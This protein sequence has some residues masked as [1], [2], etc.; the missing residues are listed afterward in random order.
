MTPTQPRGP[1]F[2]ILVVGGVGVASCCLMT[3]GVM[4]LGAFADDA[5]SSSTSG[6]EGN[7][8]LVAG[9]I[10]RGAAMTQPLSG[11]R[12]VAQYGSI[13]NNVVGRAGNFEWVQTNSS[14]S[15]Y[16]LNFDDD[17]SY[18][19]N[20]VSA[21]T[22]YGQKS[23]SHCTEKG[24]WELNGTQLVL[25]PES[26]AAEYSNSSGSQQKED[27]NLAERRY[28]V[29]DLTLETLVDPKQ[30]LPALMMI[31]P[32]AVWDTNSSDQLS[33]TLQRLSR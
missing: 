17:G 9:E 27:E 25:T 1:L 26:Q 18:V 28:T 32:K 24:Q 10:A 3:S 2:W 13:V 19:W 7:E 33:L 22:M 14:G 30:Q 6:P 15:L 23:Q 5:P 11:G 21:I 31:G 8:W 4:A 16:E 20:W 12:W 29:L